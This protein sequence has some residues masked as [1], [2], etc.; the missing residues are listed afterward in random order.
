[1]DSIRK[2]AEELQI[3]FLLNETGDFFDKY[4]KFFEIID[5]QQESIDEINELFDL[6]INIEYKTVKF[7]KESI[8]QSKWSKKEEDVQGLI[9]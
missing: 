1:M 5:E 3:N 7:V 2:I 4:D 9:Q 8:F 6:L